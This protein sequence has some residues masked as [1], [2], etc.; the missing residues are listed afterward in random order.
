LKDAFL[1]HEGRFNKFRDF[2][3]AHSLCR[4]GSVIPSIATF[5]EIAD[6]IFERL[7][8]RDDL[9]THLSDYL[10]IFVVVS[11]DPRRELL[12]DVDVFRVT[13]N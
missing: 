10:V 3:F 7:F 1:D 4:E 11:R 8:L 12:D 13:Q 6:D 9:S 5:F 2:C